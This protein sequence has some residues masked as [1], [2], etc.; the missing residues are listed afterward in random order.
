M[1]RTGGEMTKMLTPPCIKFVFESLGPHG[2]TLKNIGLKKI[3]HF[4]NGFNFCFCCEVQYIL[5]VLCMWTFYTRYMNYILQ[6][7]LINSFDFY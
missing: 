5:T 1:R 3:Q 7:S 2:K 4:V 6:N